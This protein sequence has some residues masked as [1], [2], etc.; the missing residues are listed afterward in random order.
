M[1]YSDRPLSPGELL[2]FG[3]KGMHWGVRRDRKSSSSGSTPKK[4][5]GPKSWQDPKKPAPSKK[6]AGKAFKGFN[7]MAVKDP[8]RADQIQRTQDARDRR[9]QATTVAAY[10]RALANEARVERQIKIE[11][12]GMKHLVKN[13]PPHNQSS[14]PAVNAVLNRAMSQGLDRV[15]ERAGQ[16]I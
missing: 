3:V 2:H 16:G 10:N 13:I 6:P 15:E 4:V 9:N 1:S 5:W 12:S 8:V 7:P 11:R 14:D